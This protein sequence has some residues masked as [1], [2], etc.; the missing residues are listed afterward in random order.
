MLQLI[1]KNFVKEVHMDLSADSIINYPGSF[2]N[3]CD[4][5]RLY[6]TYEANEIL[7]SNNLLHNKFLCEEYLVENG[8][9]YS[10]GLQRETMKGINNM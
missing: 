1:S 10:V 7:C 2:N 3:F 8:A 5:A 9:I 4:T 6:D